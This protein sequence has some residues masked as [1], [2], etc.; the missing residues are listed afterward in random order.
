MQLESSR[1]SELCVHGDSVLDLNK[2]DPNVNLQE[3]TFNKM[4]CI[5]SGG[6]GPKCQLC[7]L[8]HDETENTFSVGMKQ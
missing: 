7:F 3:T 1:Q 2:K 5:A 6:L 8:R 4:S